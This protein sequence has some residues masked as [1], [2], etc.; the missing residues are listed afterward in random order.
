MTD[1]RRNLIVLA[2]VGLLVALSLAL[3]IPGGPFA[4]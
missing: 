3:I 4:K 1:R 2:I